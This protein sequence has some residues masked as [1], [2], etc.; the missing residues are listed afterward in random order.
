MEIIDDELSQMLAQCKKNN[1]NYQKEKTLTV[2][3]TTTKQKKVAWLLGQ[4]NKPIVAHN[5]VDCQ[6]ICTELNNC[7][8]NRA[9][10]HK[11]FGDVPAPWTSTVHVSLDASTDRVTFSPLFISSSPSPYSGGNTFS[12]PTPGIARWIP[13]FSTTG[14][15]TTGTGIY[16]RISPFVEPAPEGNQ[17][18]I[19]TP[20]ASWSIFGIFKKGSEK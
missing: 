5:P 3:F 10:F 8:L 1:K 2:S 19:N 14:I 18:K 15:S 13:G 20:K 16:G 12:N 7:N 6:A 11:V 9:E 17:P 4:L